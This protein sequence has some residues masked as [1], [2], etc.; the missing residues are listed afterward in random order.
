[1]LSEITEL[2]NIV[3]LLRS[4]LK[5]GVNELLKDDLDKREIGGLGFIQSEKILEKMD[6]LLAETIRQQ[7]DEN[8]KGMRNEE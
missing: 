6:L 4:Q 3:P 7:R 2:K 8:A 1:M 5:G